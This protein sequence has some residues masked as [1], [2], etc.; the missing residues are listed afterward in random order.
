MPFA[1]L[2]AVMF[3]LMLITVGLDTEFGMLEGVVTPVVDM[4]LFPKLKKE[5]ISGKLSDRT[6]IED[7]LQSLF[8]FLFVFAFVHTQDRMRWEKLIREKFLKPF[9]TTL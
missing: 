6:S 8:R 7:K 5:Y 3:F 4:K 1:Q 9:R 2:W